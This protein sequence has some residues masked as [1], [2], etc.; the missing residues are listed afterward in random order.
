MPNQ[1]REGAL[2]RARENCHLGMAFE[3]AFQNI[4]QITLLKINI[5]LTVN[6]HLNSPHNSLYQHNA[7]WMKIRKNS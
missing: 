3:R 7:K 5:Q 1:G 2:H 4:S 6:Y